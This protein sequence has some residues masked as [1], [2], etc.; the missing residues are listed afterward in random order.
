MTGT[1]SLIKFC[2]FYIHILYTSLTRTLVLKE[3]FYS[4]NF[5]CKR[6][7]ISYLFFF[8]VWGFPYKFNWDCLIV[9]FGQ[10]C[11]LK[12]RLVFIFFW[13]V[14][15][16][17]VWMWMLPSTMAKCLNL[18]HFWGTNCVSTSHNMPLSELYR[19]AKGKL[20]STREKNTTCSND[21]S[22]L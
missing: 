12:P 7:A 2:N 6:S 11:V 16:S 18:K 13:R 15:N 4:V 8:F 5:N 3:R 17:R 21:L 10:A 1:L 9:G 19:M 14:K 22:F 20:E